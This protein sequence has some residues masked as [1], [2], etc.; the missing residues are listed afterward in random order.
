[1][2][3][4]ALNQHN[5]QERSVGR[6]RQAGRHL[7]V[8]SNYTL[9]ALLARGLLLA[10]SGGESSEVSF[11]DGWGW[12]LPR[13]L[14]RVPHDWAKS[15]EHA[16][17]NA[18]TI[19]LELSD[20]ERC[21][22]SAIQI[23]GDR[24]HFVHL[25]CIAKILFRSEEERNRFLSWEFEN[26]PTEGL[27]GLCHVDA[28]AFASGQ[29]RERGNGTVNEAKTIDVGRAKSDGHAGG[30]PAFETILR[31]ADVAA[32]AV[33]SLLAAG[34]E[35]KDWMAALAEIHSENA[36][37]P[38]HPLRIILSSALGGCAERSAD[39]DAVLL[40]AAVEILVHYPLAHGWPSVEI[41]KEIT[42]LAASRID[43]AS[44]STARRE[45]DDWARRCGAILEASG[46]LP[47]LTDEG[48]IVRRAI[49]LLLL[50]GDPGTL[51]ASKPD[52]V[53]SELRIG[54]KVRIL[55]LV[56]ASLRAGLRALPRELKG[57]GHAAT[58]IDLR[59]IGAR[60]FLRSYEAQVS[61]ASLIPR[62]GIHL[63]YHDRP[64]LADV[65]E[66]HAGDAM[67][68]TLPAAVD[69]RLRE[70]AVRASR[71]GID[72]VRATDNQEELELSNSANPDKYGPVRLKYCP[73]ESGGMGFVR[74]YGEAPSRDPLKRR[75]ASPP[76]RFDAL[77]KDSI[78]GVLKQHWDTCGPTRIAVSDDG[79]TLRVFLDMDVETLDDQAFRKAF[80]LVLS[81]ARHHAG[82][83]QRQ[84]RGQRRAPKS[85]ADSP[86]AANPNL[87]SDAT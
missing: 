36:I 57:V 78:I 80:E 13:V 7:I 27:M 44:D 45:L 50:R 82:W 49:L 35:H 37:G 56:L 75:S 28:S 19:A 79:S 23:G 85:G 81:T 65:W 18:F 76:K 84:P 26:V 71:L 33:T 51:L 40:A 25:D 52:D 22:D 3:E 70:F 55:A 61:G 83:G 39:L 31:R 24:L 2:K 29:A 58:W 11:L 46:R 64:L 59:T 47:P 66:V 72:A 87:E 38:V 4:L 41:L 14:D 73:G 60:V 68:V 34:L 12:S 86:S 53:D 6:G 62:T 63:R 43:G 8:T 9:P 21:D 42:R 48:S 54:P 16:A 5:E 20:G 32:A 69:P 67:L 30:S 77:S 10:P 15:I 17:R 74:L 1:M